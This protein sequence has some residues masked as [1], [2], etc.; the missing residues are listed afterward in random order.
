MERRYP[1]VDTL[2]SFL[3]G[4]GFDDIRSYVPLDAVL[5]VMRVVN[6]RLWSIVAGDDDDSIA[7]LMMMAVIIII[8]IVVMIYMIDDGD[9]KD[10]DV[11]DDKDKDVGND[12]DGGYDAMVIMIG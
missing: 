9:D 5:Q 6:H 7:I 10:K 2:G 11:G 3:A 8:L 12:D 4:A 1:P